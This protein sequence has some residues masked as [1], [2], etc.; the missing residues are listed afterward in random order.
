MAL[1]CQ[2]I[3]LFMGASGVLKFL[4]I[5][6]AEAFIRFPIITFGEYFCYKKST[7]NEIKLKIS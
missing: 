1:N 2:C 6:P 4:K 5:A 7:K 3:L